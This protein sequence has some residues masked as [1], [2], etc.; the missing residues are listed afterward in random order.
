MAQY[1]YFSNFESSE[2][3]D[4]GD[5]AARVK[6]WGP[7]E[8]HGKVHSNDDIW[9]QQA[10]GGINNDWPTFHKLVTTAGGFKYY[11]TG[12]PLETVAPMD[13]IFLDGWEEDVPPIV[14]DP[15]ADDIRANGVRPFPPDIDIV[16]VKLNGSGFESMIATVDRQGD[17]EL[18]VYSWFP[19]NANM[20]NAVIAA[21]GNWFE[22]SDNVWTNHIPEYDT[23]WTTGPPAY[24]A[25]QSVWVDCELWIEGEVSG[26]ITFG[27]ADTV[28]IVGDITY[29]N[30]E[31]LEPPDGDDNPNLIDYFGLVSEEKL[32]I[33]YK[34]R[35]PFADMVVRTDNCTDIALYGA[36]AA[37]GKGDLQLYGDLAC[38]YDG[39][40]TFEYQHPHGST[41]SFNALSP[42]TGQ[43]TLYKYVDLQRFIYPPN[44]FVPPDVD[45]F[46]M[47]GSVPTLLNVCGYPIE[48]SFALDP[49]GHAASYPNNGPN[50]VYPNG[51]DYPWYNPIWPESQQ[52]IVYERGVIHMWGAIAQRRRGF[53]HRSG[54]DPYNH[55]QGNQSPSPWNMDQY[56]YD[57]FHPSTGYDKDYHYDQRFMFVQPPD[58][59]EIY[60]GFG[61]STLSA[62]QEDNW[63]F[64]V[65]Q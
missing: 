8:L 58:Y 54:I 15:N 17:K 30:T 32:L 64:K 42:Y 59:P 34:H 33:R 13:D 48:S 49:N 46:V 29:T 43:D 31:Y 51:T 47:H 19:T 21:G 2:N 52:T 7:D 9:V 28:Y 40:F 5:E 62:F 4:G 35:D 11:P 22:D 14:Y 44:A 23:T 6:F 18:D 41:P 27:C 60:R 24:L 36:F 3:A 26:K 61:E 12:Q 63:V 53:V 39:I 50:Y 16:Y 25:N 57:G 37:I 55:P 20:A 38:H 45:G 56:H 10:G 65:P 1:Q